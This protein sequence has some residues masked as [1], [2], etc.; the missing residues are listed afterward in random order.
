M[1]RREAIDYL[2]PIMESASL[3]GYQA[4]LRLAVEALEDRIKLDEEEALACNGPRCSSC[5]YL[6]RTG[7]D[8]YY[9]ILLSRLTVPALHCDDYVSWPYKELDIDETT[10]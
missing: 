3:P 6:A 9:C 10:N 8:T 1:T 2:R 7:A 5:R 4:A